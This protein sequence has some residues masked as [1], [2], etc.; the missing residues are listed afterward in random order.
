M[1]EPLQ[2]AGRRTWLKQHDGERRWL[3]LA[4]LDLG[5]RL[6]GLRC[7]RPPPRLKA[8]QACQLE[9]RRLRELAAHGVPVPRVLGHGETA[10]LLEDGGPSLAQRLRRCAPGEAEHLMRLAA[11]E[12]LRVHL[13]GCCV[14]QPVA[15]NIAVDEACCIRFLDLEE[16]PLQVMALAEAQARDWLLFISGTVRHAGLPACALVAVLGH[17]LRQTG[18]DVQQLLRGAVCRLRFLPALCRFAGRRAR[19]LGDSVL[20][21]RRALA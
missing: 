19:G 21:L 7:L 17:C 16:D 4:A 3:A 14:G 11:N 18:P 2:I 20:I 5:V 15:R 6:L 1:V 13:A 9:R 12:L 10:L 8:E